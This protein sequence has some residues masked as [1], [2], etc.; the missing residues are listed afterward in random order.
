MCFL[1]QLMMIL[2]LLC[3][4]IIYLVLYICFCCLKRMLRM[5][6][7]WKSKHYL[8]NMTI[9]AKTKAYC[10]YDGSGFLN[11]IYRL[12][13]IKTHSLSALVMSCLLEPFLPFKNVRDL[14]RNLSI[15]TFHSSHASSASFSMISTRSN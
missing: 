13:Y 8:C 1:E 3:I 4:I 15:Q 5:L 11:V 14:V 10:I 7:T 12:C 6:V 9:F 2:C